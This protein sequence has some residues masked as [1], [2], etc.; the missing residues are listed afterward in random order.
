MKSLYKLYLNNP[1]CCTLEEQCKILSCLAY[2]VYFRRV[3]TGNRFVYILNSFF[4]LDVAGW[5]RV[6]SCELLGNCVGCN[7]NTHTAHACDAKIPKMNIK[8]LC[9]CNCCLILIIC[10]GLM[11]Q[12]AIAYSIIDLNFEKGSSFVIRPSYIQLNCSFVKP[13]T[14]LPQGCCEKCLDT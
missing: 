10:A 3:C 11:S 7:P 13:K 9:K 6:A 1:N 12:F 2:L 4:S 5:L 8:Q 14:L